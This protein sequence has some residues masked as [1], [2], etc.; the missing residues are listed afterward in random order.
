MHIVNVSVENNNNNTIWRGS[1]LTGEEPSPQS[2]ELKHALRQ[3]GQT[4]SQLSRSMSSGHHISMEHRLWKKQ[5]NSETNARKQKN[6]EKHFLKRKR[7]EKKNKIQE[8]EKEKKKKKEKEKKGR[9]RKGKE[10]SKGYHPRRAEQMNFLKEKE[11]R[12][13]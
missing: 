12:K 2:G 7:K 1:V 6:K 5:L 10:A 8:K 4:Q 11:K 13:K 3:E 9:K